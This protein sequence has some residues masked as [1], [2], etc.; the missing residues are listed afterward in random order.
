MV[1]PDLFIFD[2]FQTEGRGTE[3]AVLLQKRQPCSSH[4]KLRQMGAE[5]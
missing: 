3:S 1:K 2:A 5:I 4:C